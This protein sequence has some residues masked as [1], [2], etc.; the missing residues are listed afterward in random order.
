MRRLSR[1]LPFI[2]AL[3]LSS[4]L[5]G[6][7]SRPPGE[8]R[9]T[10]SCRDASGGCAGALP[11]SAGGHTRDLTLPP[12]SLTVA[13][14]VLQ[15]PD[16]KAAMARSNAAAS[17]ID[18]AYAMRR[19]QA[20]LETYA[21]YGSNDLYN[22]TRNGNVYSYALTV[23]MPLYQGGRDAAAI[24]LAQSRYR[25]TVES[26]KDVL[27]STT[28]S[29]LTAMAQLRRHEESIATIDRHLKTLRRLRETVVSEKSTGSSTAVDVG[30]V[31]RQLLRL[32][33][34]RRQTDL[35]RTDAREAILRLNAAGAKAVG[36]PSGAITR[37]PQDLPSLLAL[38]MR[39][40]PRV[41]TRSAQVDAAAARVDQA[42]A[43]YN[44]SLSLDVSMSG[45]R[46][47]PD[48]GRELDGTA[49]LRLSVPLYSGGAR[50]AGIASS[51]EEFIAASF[52]KDSAASGVRAAVTT[53]F[54]RRRQS[55]TM[56]ET[57]K[58]QL[59][60][61]R[62]QIEGVRAERKLGERTVFD[63]IRAIADM[64]DAELDV[65]SGYYEVTVSDLLLLAETGQ[66]DDATGVAAM[67]A[68]GAPFMP[69]APAKG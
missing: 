27:I 60:V 3:G 29:L 1:T 34:V 9:E 42:R 39:E 30:E 57:A 41:S 25:A 50:E 19:P 14:A 68:S 45:E 5:V 53:A 67:P 44:P 52:D 4:M 49:R 51:R 47:T 48:T 69:D 16:V 24:A 8:G 23:S 10:A 7:A 38:A 54:D 12:S 11:S 58:R 46:S 37:L 26:S 28:L 20:N 63:E 40:N 32:E 33:V 22:T 18:S 17:G 56:L 31:D 66:L 6:C 61:A 36:V 59:S 13:D 43:A 65:I 21:G 15:S 55:R 2:I 64:A 62:A 35:A